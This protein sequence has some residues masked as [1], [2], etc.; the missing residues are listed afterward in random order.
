MQ[1]N[2]NNKISGWGVRAEDG[3]E[4]WDAPPVF[5]GETVR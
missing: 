1:Y 2:H 3:T 5:V 4:I